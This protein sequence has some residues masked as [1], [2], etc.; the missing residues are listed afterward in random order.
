MSD[1]DANHFGYGARY[2]C[3]DF[4][5]YCGCQSARYRGEDL[6]IQTG[7]YFGSDIGRGIHPRIRAAIGLEGLAVRAVA[8]NRKHVIIGLGACG[9]R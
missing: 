4:A 9:F 7:L 1:A 6:H 5:R 3:S 2:L 8:E